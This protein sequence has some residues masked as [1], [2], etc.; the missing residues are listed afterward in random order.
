MSSVLT[1]DVEKPDAVFARS[2]IIALIAFLTLIDLFGAQALVPALTKSFNASPADVGVAVNASTIGM[3]LTGVVVALFANKID[4][5]TGIWVSLACLSVPTVMLGFVDDLLLFTA[6]RI[7]QGVFMAAAFTLTLS[8]LSSICTITAARGAMAAYITGNVAS[9]FFGRLL[10]SGVASEFGLAQTFYVLGALNCA[11]AILAFVYFGQKRSTQKMAG[12]QMERT[13]LDLKVLANTPLLSAF[14]IG[15]ALLF[16]FVGV[17][18]YVNLVLAEA[19][20]SLDQVA[21]GLAYIT[22]L[23]AMISTPLASVAASRLG[24]RPAFAIGMATSLAGLILLLG[25]SLSSVLLGLTLIAM[26]LFF[27]QAVITGFV[28]QAAGT[29]AAV[30]NGIYLT[31]YY[32]GGIVGASLLGAVFVTAGW[33]TMVTVM[34]ISILLASA[35]GIKLYAP[36]SEPAHKTHTMRH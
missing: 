22:F 30:A 3:A 25:S 8:H 18:T 20:F 31:C 16:V 13:G 17:F 2:A 15:F 4:K 14:L 24:T 9:N 1:T 7:V 34:I 12:H 19:P 28:G 21:L 33:P 26:G 29:S 11:G 6:I 35:A 32:L 10:A 5:R 23:P 36:D 27:A